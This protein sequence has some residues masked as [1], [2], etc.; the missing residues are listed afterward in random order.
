MN[1]MHCVIV[2]A[3]GDPDFIW[4]EGNLIKKFKDTTQGKLKYCQCFSVYFV[5]SDNSIHVA[6]TAY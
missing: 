1:H 5:L 2:G 6:L 4:L 3:S